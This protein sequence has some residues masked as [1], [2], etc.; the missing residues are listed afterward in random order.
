MR[1]SLISV[2]LAAVVGQL[3]ATPA[4]AQQ[5]PN[6]P[7]CRQ[8]MDYA[9]SAGATGTYGP[10]IQLYNACMSSAAGQP[11]VDQYECGPGAYL[12]YCGNEPRCV[13]SPADL[14]DCEANY[15]VNP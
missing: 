13:S 6:T 2:V 10:L 1:T 15:D 3:T 14:E 5:L 12:H 7:E 4:A 11:Q 8:Y 9:R